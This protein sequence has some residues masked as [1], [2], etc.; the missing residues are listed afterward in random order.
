VAFATGYILVW[1]GFAAL[2]SAGQVALAGAGLLDPGGRLGSGLAASLLIAAGLYQL[3]P[4]KA[5]CLAHCRS[6][7]MTLM[8]RWRAGLGGAVRMGL[9]NGLYCLGCCWALMLLAFVGGTMN[10]V[11]MGIAT[12]LMALEKLPRIGRPLTLP[13]GIALVSAGAMLLVSLMASPQG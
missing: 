9:G 13:L 10:L 6:P 2:A 3:S 7:V 5:M 8:A 11:W 1:L 4:I 12:V